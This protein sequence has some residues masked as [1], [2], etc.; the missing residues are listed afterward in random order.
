MFPTE[1]IAL[2]SK[3][4]TSAEEITRLDELVGIFKLA[5]G[6]NEELFDGEPLVIR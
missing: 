6:K 4:D 1:L 3:Q 5:T 2:C